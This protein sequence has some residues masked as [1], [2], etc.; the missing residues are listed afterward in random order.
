VIL[1]LGYFMGA[2]GRGNVAAL[3]REGTER[4]SDIHGVL[5]IALDANWELR[6]AKE[7][8]AAGLP[9]DLNKV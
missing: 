9:V 7:I 3:Y 4:P 5:Y 6:L 1:E 8:K 2:I